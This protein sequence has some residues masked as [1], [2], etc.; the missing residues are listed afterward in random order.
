ME[1]TTHVPPIPVHWD[2]LYKI[3]YGCPVLLKVYKPFLLQERLLFSG[4]IF[5]NMIPS[6]T[7]SD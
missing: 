1:L 4:I 6:P 3:L 2:Y 5:Q 7:V